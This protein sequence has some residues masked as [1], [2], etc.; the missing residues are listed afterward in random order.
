MLAPLDQAL[1][2]AMVQRDLNGMRQALRDGANPHAIEGG[3]PLWFQCTQ[4]RIPGMLKVFLDAGADPN[5]R[6][7]R[8]GQGMSLLLA[9]AYQ[10]QIDEFE[11]ALARGGDPHALSPSQNGVVLYA[12]FNGRPDV[13]NRAIQAAP[14]Q[15]RPDVDRDH[16]L[17][18]KG[19]PLQHAIAYNAP[20]C[21]ELVTLLLD[22]GA[23]AHE[24]VGALSLVEFAQ[25]RNNL[26]AAAVLERW[27]LREQMSRND[28]ESEPS[29]RSRVRL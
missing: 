22:A 27:W 25:Q 4:F 16:P 14:E 10:G 23:D 9:T 26:A 29:A 12:V 20:Q 17:A 21:A 7:E 1:H 18:M 19:T 15:V 24:R 3:I 5:D 28:H 11:L 6:F 13:L 2:D 8:P